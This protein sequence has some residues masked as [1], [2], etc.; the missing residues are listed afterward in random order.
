VD[1]YVRRAAPFARPILEVVR[2]AFHAGCPDVVETVK[3]GHPSFEHHGLLGGMAAFKAHVTFGFWRGRD[4]DDPAG[5]LGEGR[6]AGPRSGRYRDVSDLPPKRV[7]VQFVRAAAKL[8]E[9]G[10]RPQRTPARPRARPEAPAWFLEA[11]RAVPAADATWSRLTPGYRHEYVEWVT[12]AK[13]DETREKRVA[14]S[15]EWLAEGRTRN[16]KYRTC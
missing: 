1:A 16:W 3:W 12:E 11:I 14:Q 13:R 2:A 7:L 15:V 6:S 9:S 8:N 5:I 4:L 10:P